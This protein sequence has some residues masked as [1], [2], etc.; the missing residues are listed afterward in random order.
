MTPHSTTGADRRTFLQQAGLGAL[1]TAAAVQLTAPARAANANERI[2]IGLIGCG[3]RGTGV[4]TTFTKLPNVEL[5]YA[6]DP[7]STRRGVT[8]EKLGSASGR[9]LEMVGDLRK[10]LDDKSI[11]AV[12]IATPDHWHAPASLLAL[13]AGKHVY[14]EKPCSHNIR[15]G[16][17]MVEAARRH[18][19]TVQT[20]TQ[21]R[22]GPHIRRAMELLHNGAIG[23]ILVAKAWNSQ[24]RRSIGHEM[25]SDKPADLDFD[26]W[27]GPAPMVPYQKNLLH[28]G[29]RWL[30]PFGTGDM[31]NDGV[32][33]IDLARAGLGVQGHPSRVMAM[34]GK[35]FY[36]D[37]Q[38]FPDT[39]TV[40]FEYPGAAS[41]GRPKQLIFEMRLWSQYVQEGYENGNAFYGT[42]GMMLLGKGNN[43]QMFGI[44]NTPL[45]TGTFT[46][47]EVPHAQNFI[48]CMRSGE[49]PNADVEIGHLSA[50]LCH[51]GNL[52]TRVGRP[53]QF[54]PQK[55]QIIGDDE[56]N[57]LVRRDYRAGHWATPQGV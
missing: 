11:N 33:D 1:T 49:L 40:L 31:G 10:V 57:Q 52:A 2:R 12:I 51:L 3:G 43:F 28:Y 55:E 14:V 17:L 53:L 36:D 37:D 18:K 45:E 50:S 22:S 32:H 25:P 39:Q 13:A 30:Y 9:K 47:R 54:D 23:E 8:A 6:C 4:A 21:S 48:D 15:E 19:L 20:G 46:D 26:M 34:G 56:A 24:K 42:K 38:Q 44:K 41:T 16:R 29:W 35:Y 5:V 7:D 27:I